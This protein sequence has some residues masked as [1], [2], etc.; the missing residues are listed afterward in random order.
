MNTAQPGWS[1]KSSQIV[2]LI[3]ISGGP[4]G[5]M[6]RMAVMKPSIS[7]PGTPAMS[8]PMTAARPCASPVP[9]MP[10]ITPLMVPPTISSRRPATLPAT[11]SRPLRRD[12]ASA[13]PSR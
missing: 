5:T 3:Q 4:A 7:A 6:E 13:A 12:C 1:W 11:R 8:K 10:Y 2:A 9:T